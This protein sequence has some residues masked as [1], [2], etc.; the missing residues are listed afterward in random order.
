VLSTSIVQCGVAILILASQ[1]LL[2]ALVIDE[3]PPPALLDVE[4]EEPPSHPV[5]NPGWRWHRPR[6]LKDWG[7]LDSSVG[8]QVSSQEHF[9]TV[10]VAVAVF[11]LNEAIGKDHRLDVYIVR[12]VALYGIVWATMRYAAR[13]NDDDLA[14]KILWAL[15]E[16]GLL[17]IM[18][19]QSMGSDLSNGRW[20]VYKIS[21]IA[22]YALVIAF[23]CGRV[24]RA[25]ERAR[26][27]C[28][29]SAC[30][31][32]ACAALWL[33]CA[34]TDGPAL[35]FMWPL[36][37]LIFAFDAVFVVV[38]SMT[39][40]E[41]AKQL[42][43]PMNIEYMVDR[44]NGLF[45]EVLGVAVIVPTAVYP[46]TS[47]NMPVL[48]MEAL[49]ALLA[50][51]LKAGLLDIEPTSLKSHAIR[52][53][54]W[55]AVTFLSVFPLTVGALCTTGAALAM[56]VNA[57]LAEG[58]E[59]HSQFAQQL[60]GGSQAV[61]WGMLTVTKLLHHRCPIRSPSWTNH[62]LKIAIQAVGTVVFIILAICGDD[63]WKDIVTVSIISATVAIIAC[64]QL[65]IGAVFQ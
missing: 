16:V 14:H 58:Y 33:A 52:R 44:Q 36:A 8:A 50:V 48:A 6:L 38:T 64:S 41:A 7:T 13:F 31:H 51:A 29:M 54:R 34:F 56:L 23:F 46:G 55:S 62:Y 18:E 42:D 27:F 26:N 57:A 28:L 19:G 3:R 10:L 61:M 25:V 22:L 45:M 24:A 59:A 43:V 21:Y 11:Q 35:G 40:K 2:E 30:V 63:E 20:S 60:L 47:N 65:A 32:M 15:Y 53:A 1:L 12:F 39:S 37:L 4:G 9:F 17:L 5:A 49:A